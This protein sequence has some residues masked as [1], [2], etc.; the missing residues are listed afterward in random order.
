V[1]F[2]RRRAVQVQHSRFV[3]QALRH[4]PTDFAKLV[5]SR[6]QDTF[7]ICTVRPAGMLSITR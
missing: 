6:H 3:V 5:Y 7:S 4:S 1:D 2:A